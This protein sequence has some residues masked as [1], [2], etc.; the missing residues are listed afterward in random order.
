MNEKDQFDIKYW[1]GDYF[2][3]HQN[4]EQPKRTVRKKLLIVF[5]FIGILALL[6]ITMIGLTNL[7]IN[8]AKKI[9]VASEPQAFEKK[10]TVNQNTKAEASKTSTIEVVNNDSYWKISKRACGTGKYYLSIQAQN[11]GK[12]LYKGE[13]VTVDCS[14]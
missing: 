6:P 3:V 13:N 7:N 5:S 4:E 11:G 8:Q 1:G 2:Y 12:A 9:S 10:K 14:L